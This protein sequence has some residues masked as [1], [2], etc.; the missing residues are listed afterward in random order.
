[1]EQS[2]LALTQTSG[3]GLWARVPVAEKLNKRLVDW[4]GC[5]L[6]ADFCLYHHQRDAV[7]EQHDIRDDT[8]LHAPRRINAELI[9]RVEDVPL[10]VG[11]V[12]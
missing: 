3:E 4:I 6:I 1:M 9:D 11:E 5:V 8:G 7:D 2:R 12:D 10:R